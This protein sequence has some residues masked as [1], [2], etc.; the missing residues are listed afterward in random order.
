M[1]SKG[2]KG[3][4][5]HETDRTGTVGPSRSG[6]GPP[7]GRP[8]EGRVSVRT[9]LIHAGSY[10]SG[11]SPERSFRP[12]FTRGSSDFNSATSYVP[13][14]HFLPV[15][16]KTTVEADRVQNGEKEKGTVGV[17]HSGERV[18][19]FRGRPPGPPQFRRGVDTCNKRST[20]FISV[21]D[22][23]L[24]EWGRRENRVTTRSTNRK[25]C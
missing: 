10:P 13:P 18:V 21:R 19:W 8:K 12:V 9:E 5:G 2:E 16:W 22:T 7:I 1:G 14:L 3:V 4:T 23:G 6:R 25:I 11:R 20:S 24:P 15:W 17:V